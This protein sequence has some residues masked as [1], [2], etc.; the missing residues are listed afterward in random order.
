MDLVLM[1]EMISKVLL[2]FNE[3]PCGVRYRL[4]FFANCLKVY[5]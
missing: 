5:S 2:E 4:S 1:N 3:N